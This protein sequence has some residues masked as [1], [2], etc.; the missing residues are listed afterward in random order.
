M[1]P[2]RTLPP[3]QATALGLLHGPSELLP[4]SSSAH[5]T[6]VPWLL[7]WRYGELAPRTR[8]AFEVGLHVGTAA[9]LLTR[10]PWSGRRPRLRT[11][12]CAIAPPA[13]TGYLLGERIERR[14]GTPPTIAAGLLAG[15]AF[16]AV[17]ERGAIERGADSADARDGVAL[18]AAQ[19]L[20]LVPGLS[21][22]GMTTAAA[23]RRGFAHVDADRLS[24]QVGLPVIGGAALL[25][26]ARLARSGIPAPERRSLAAGAGAAFCS[27]HLSA[28]LITPDR[29]VRL[30]FIT[31]LY[32]IALAATVLA[33]MAV[34]PARTKTQSKQR[35]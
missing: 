19:A 9:A 26:G 17:A 21:R 1:S 16:S 4:V 35:R 15:A 22:S 2:A 18:G 27:T 20:A 5:T 3:A 31:V 30:R 25:Q 14:L 6:L 10:H 23:R 34:R 8:K 24:W 29:R 13:L 28:R 12:A 7:G 32:R 11:L 33:R